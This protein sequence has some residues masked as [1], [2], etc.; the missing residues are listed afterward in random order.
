MT[1]DTS[2]K[3]IL[4]V[5]VPLMVSS[6][7]QSIVLITDAAFVSRYSTMAFDAVGNGGLIYVTLFMALAGMGDGA[8]IILARRIGQKNTS[9]IGRIVGTSFLI[10]FLLAAIFFLISQFIL[11]GMLMSFVKDKMLGTMQC[12]FIQI[13]SYALFFAMIQLTLQA[14]YL[15]QGKTWIVLIGALITAFSNILLDYLL[16][17]GIGSFPELG[18]H[19]AAYAS[20]I[21]EGLGM[22]FLLIYSFLAKSNVQFNLFKYFSFDFNS[23][24]ELLRTGSPLMLQGFMAIATWTLFFSWIEQIGNFE[25]TVSQN[26]RALYFLAFVPIWGFAGTTKTYISQYIGRKD[27]GSLRK[28]QQRIQFLTML[29]LLLFFH[30]ALLYPEK[31][32]EMIN[33]SE[34]HII[35]SANILRFIFAS[36]LMFG[37]FSVYFQTINGS[38]NTIVS[39][40]VEMICLFFYLSAA[41]LF[42]KVWHLPIFYIWSVEYIYFGCLGLFSLLYLYLFDWKQKVV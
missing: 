4:S 6:F 34:V 22:I 27:F 29:F 31:I 3:T 16:I 21:A 12:E 18:T 41:Y 15:A 24:K 25:L 26:V 35:E 13:R 42:I 38:G 7:I 39:F 11:P 33:P 8:Q 5:A 10:H 32:I 20:S 2:Y 23:V 1:L 9:A 17:F 14:F 19:G 36:I 28:I 30:G 40:S 37:F